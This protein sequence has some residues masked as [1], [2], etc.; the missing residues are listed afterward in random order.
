MEDTGIGIPDDK[1][2]AIFDRFTQADPGIARKYGGTGLGLAICRELVHGMGGSIGASSC[3]GRG[4]TF[5]V[6]LQLPTA[7]PSQAATVAHGR[8]D[9][10]P[11]PPSPRPGDP[12]APRVLVAEDNEINQRLA[13]HMLE[14]L[15]CRVDTAADGEEALRSLQQRAYD[16]VFMDCQMPELD[17]FEGH[18][19]AP[20]SRRCRRT[21]HSRDRNDGT[22]H[23]G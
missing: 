17:G 16:I 2:T 1:L 13:V 11:S 15:G 12:S 18:R 20:P 22:G 3:V 23:E 9:I 19:H 7:L 14:K 10:P 6:R 5:W 4:S 21:A 8:Q